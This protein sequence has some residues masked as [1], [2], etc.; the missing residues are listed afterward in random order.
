MNLF[1]KVNE[2]KYKWNKFTP[3]VKCLIIFFISLTIYLINDRTISSGDTVPNSLLVFNLLENQTFNFDAF[4]TSYFANGGSL[5]YSFIEAQNG[6]LTSVYPIGAAILTSPIYVIFY[7]FLKLFNLPVE[8]T[9]SSFEPYRL[10]FEKLAASL[11]T[12]SSVVVFYLASK[13]KFSEKIAVISTFIFAFATNTWMTSSQGLWQHGASNFAV[14]VI[15]F[16]LLKVNHTTVQKNKLLFLVIAGMMGGLLP[17]IRPTSTLFLV[18]ALAYSVVINR[19]NN[20]FFL[21]GMLSILPGLMWNLY[22]FNNL[23]GGYSQVG[24]SWYSF[25]L[26]TFLESSLG[27]LISPSRGVLLFS[28]ILIYSFIG[29]Y[30]LFKHRFRK[31][32]QL[33]LCMTTAVILLFFNYCFYLVWWAGH[34]Y[35]PRF[36][37]DIMPVACYVINYSLI[38]VTQK[39]VIYKKK[40][41]SSF[42][43]LSLLMFSLFTQIVGAFGHK[44]FDWNG[45]PLNIDTYRFRLW[46]LKDNQ[47]ERHAKA[48]FHR[49]F[50]PPVKSNKYINGLSGSIEAIEFA[51]QKMTNKKLL[52]SAKSE[53]LLK[54]KVKNTGSSQ[55]FGYQSALR[56]GETRVRVVFYDIQDNLV[57]E[58]YLY[59]SGL[60][61][62]GET[63]QAIGT[64]VIPEQPGVYKM[65]FELVSDHNVMFPENSDNPYNLQIVVK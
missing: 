5:H 37:T 14:I 25:T 19:F 42:V 40:I 1:N 22:Y 13:L 62:Q 57:K 10:F 24:Q 7:G 47:I 55:W 53:I 51:N 16:C 56:K 23:T 27:T 4:R 2:L 49:L 54:A 20:L 39:P 65:V 60:V 64:V 36:M 38:D 59:V 29:A 32:E 17:I 9:Q 43:F 30:N 61:S 26:D 31:D 33:I 8:L 11:V 12:A 6:H 3:R 35:G 28:P 44:G 58:S 18:A 45:Y 41:F 15:I 21:L 48:L 34:S 46:Q 50:A 52:L 63:T